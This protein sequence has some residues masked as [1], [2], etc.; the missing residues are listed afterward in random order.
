MF[1]FL[2]SVGIGLGAVNA[3]GQVYGYTDE[4]GRLVL[5]NVPSDP[6]M[7]LIAEGSAETTGRIWYYRGQYDDLILRAASLARLDSALIRAVI[8]IES[9]F[10]RFARSHKGAMGLMQL[11]PDTCRRYRVSHPYNAWQNIRAGAEH[12]RD[13]LDEFGDLNL[14]LA[15]YNAGATPVRRLRTI[16]P[17]RETRDY[18][19]KVM[20]VYR[21]GSKISI[22]KAG[23]TYSIGPGGKTVVQT[24]SPATDT[25]RSR[26]VRVPAG[27]KMT[28]GE[29]AA[30][31]RR[32]ARQ[33]SESAGTEQETPRAAAANGLEDHDGHAGPSSIGE[34]GGADPTADEPDAFDREDASHGSVILNLESPLYYRYTDE[35]GVIYITRR[36]PAHANYEVLR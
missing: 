30:A 12:L 22:T 17:Y 5:S 35:D 29:I 14:A 23:R 2:A 1:L 9:G 31:A 34:M 27:Q 6:N 11:M 21:A 18:V 16:P 7:R 4:N 20:A 10:N 28:L 24:S 32:A 3:R 19:R 36:K 8:A 13:L 15:A 25:V 26:P 33:T